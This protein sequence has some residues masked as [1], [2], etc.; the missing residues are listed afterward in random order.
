MVPA[1]SLH[2][3]G[4]G[5]ATLSTS[6]RCDAADFH[7]HPPTP[8]PSLSLLKPAVQNARLGWTHRAALLWLQPQQGGIELKE[9]KIISQSSSDGKVSG[10]C[11]MEQEEERLGKPR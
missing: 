10:G 9:T 2:V 5:P 8:P 1:P 7:T 4:S 6:P 11:M 3:A